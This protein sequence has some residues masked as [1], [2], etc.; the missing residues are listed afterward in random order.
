VPRTCWK[1]SGGRLVWAELGQ[2]GPGGDAELGV[3][4]VQV[5]ANRVPAY[6]QPLGDLLIAKSL[7]GEA[8]DL[9]LLGG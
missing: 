7:A 1:V 3:H 2:L 4:L 5:V 8:G 6:E 9:P